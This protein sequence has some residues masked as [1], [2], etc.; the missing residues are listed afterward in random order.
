MSTADEIEQDCKVLP[1]SFNM[2]GSQIERMT[3]CLDRQSSAASLDEPSLHK[4]LG[5]PVPSVVA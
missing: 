5:G 2:A 1:P 3:T 4:K